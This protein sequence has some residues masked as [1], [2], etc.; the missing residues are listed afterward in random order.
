MLLSVDESKIKH[1]ITGSL[2]A[3]FVRL[4][5]IV[6]ALCEPENMLHYRQHA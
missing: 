5:V 3:G 2:K 6:C 4:I 1:L